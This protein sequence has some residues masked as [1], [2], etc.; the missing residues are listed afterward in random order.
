MRVFFNKQLYSRANLTLLIL[1]CFLTITN[2]GKSQTVINGNVNNSVKIISITDPGCADCDNT[3]ACRYTIEV[4]DANG[5]NVGDRVLIVQ[6]KGATIDVTN[7]AAGGE[8]TDIG[9]AGNYEFFIVGSVDA[10]NN[11]IYPRGKLKRT[12]DDAGLVQLVKVPSYSGDTEINSNIIG[13]AWDPTT[14]HGGVVAIFVDGTL[15]LNADIDVSGRGYQGVQMLVNGT[16][17]DC[18]INPSTQMI[19][20]SSTSNGAFKGQGIVIDNSSYNKG[21]APRANGGGGGVSGDSGGGG[22]SNYGSG[23]KGGDRWCDVGGAPAGGLGGIAMSTYISQNRIFFGGAGGAGFV[24]TNNPSSAAHGGGL[25]I[26][27]AKKIIG[28][29]HLIN[30]AGTSPIAVNPTGSPDGGGGGGG[31]GTVVFEIQDFESTIN[32]DVSGGNG[33]DLNTNTI[34]GPG[35]GG[36]GGAFLYNLM[37]L[38]AGITVTAT[39]G[40]GGQHLNAERN[41]SVDGS[42]GGIV[43]YFNLVYSEE[44]ADNDDISDFCDLDTDNDG[45]PDADED[46]NTGFDPSKDADNDGIPN[47]KDNDDATPGFPAFVDTNGD[48]VNDVYDKDKDHI[49]DF[50]DLDSDNDGRVDA[51]EAGGLADA[52][53]VMSNYTDTDLDGLND[54]VDPDNGGT[55][56]SPTDFDNDGIPDFLDLD[57]DD[58]GVSDAYESATSTIATGNDDDNDGI[59]NAFDPD[60]SG[61]Y[62][63]LIDRDGDTHYDM[64]DIDSDNDGITDYIESSGI[65]PTGTDTDNDGIDDAYDVDITGGTDTDEDWIDDASKPKDKDADG[66]FDIYDIDADADGI[67]DNIEGQVTAGYIAPSGNDTDADGLDDAYDTDNGGTTIIPT[68][69]DGDLVA[70]FLDTNSDDDL[71]SDLIEAYDSDNDGVSNILPAGTDTDGDGLDDNYDAITGFDPT[72]GGEVP[73]DYPDLDNPGGDRDWRQN[74]PTV[75]LSLDKATIAENAE[76]ATITATLSNTTFVDVTVNLVYSGTASGTDYNAA[77]GTNA[78]N[79]VT[80]VIPAGQLI[81][82]V[83]I[84]SVQD[85]LEEANETVIVDVNSVVN[86]TESGT[87]TVTTTIVD[88]DINT[89]LRIVK[90]VDNE[91][92]SVG[93]NVIFTLTATNNGPSTATGVSVT[94]NLPTGYTYVSDDGAGAYSGG[95]WTIGNLANGASATLNI[96]VAVNASGNYNNTATIDG[97]QYDPDA[98][99]NTSSKSASPVAKADLSIAKSVDN[100]TPNVG[101]NIVFTLTVTNNGP[102]NAT[103][104]SVTD[105]LPAGYTYVSDDGSGAYSGGT[106]TVGNLANGASATLNITVSVNATGSYANT[107]S[108][109]GDQNDPDTT[110]DSDTNTPSPN[111]QTDLSIVKTVDNST[112]NVG[113]NVVFTL[114]VTNNGPNDATG[115]SITDNLPTGYTYVSDDGSGA[116]S[117]GI[118]TV[119]N[120]ANSTS[121]TLN[122]IAT[123][124]ASGNY[125]NTAS[126]TGNENDPDA[127][128]NTSSKTTTP[129]S[130]TDLSITKTVDNSTPNVG[131]N[132]VFTLT[133]TNNGPSDATGVSVTDNLPAGYTYVSDDGSGAYSGG[134]WTVGN[135]ANGA[136]ATLNIT[137][138][139]NATGS[140]A[141]TASVSGDQ[142]DPDATDD[143]DT[144]TPTPGL[145]TSPTAQ[146]DNVTVDED[147]G[148]NNVFVLTDNGNGADDFGDNGPSTGTINI[149]SLP[150]HGTATVND[151][152][153]PNDPTDDFIVYTPDSEYHGNDSFTYEIC[154]VD[155][156][157]AS[158]TVNIT[159]NSVNDLPVAIDDNAS[160]SVDGT[161]NSSV[162]GNDTGLGDTPVTFSLTTDVSNGTLTFNTDGTYTYIPNAGYVGNDSFTYTV[163]DTDGDCSTATVT[164]TIFASDNQPVAMNDEVNVNEDE[165]INS[166]VSGND[167]GLN[168]TPVT[169]T[170]ITDV[171]NGTL[172]LNTDG[173]FTYTPDENFNGEDGFTYTVCDVDGDCSNATVSITVLP[174]NDPPEANPDYATVDM[175][176]SRITINVAENDTDVDDNIDERTVILVRTS[177]NGSSVSVD[178]LGGINYTPAEGFYGID[179]IPYQIFDTDGLSDIDTLFVTVNA[180]VTVPNT[181]TPNGDGINDVLVIPGIEDYDNEIFIYNRWGN[182]VYHVV[183]Y[184]NDV[185]AWDGRAQNK[186][187]F[188]G[189]QILPVGTYFYILKLKGENKPIKGYVYLQY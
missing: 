6:M 150:T 163:C 3:P 55:P 81:G 37:S 62:N 183:N 100:S 104:V 23:G 35:G 128:D 151:N 27:R 58:D 22:G 48:G 115:V 26:I 130:Q 43:S 144:N 114:T 36:G 90:T 64:F 94:D 13:E 121:A 79:A 102:S 80:I 92:P 113:D 186:V 154:D 117:S 50:K 169:F 172:T 45:V 132:V 116:Y 105:N 86:G 49:P 78:T 185:N 21:R 118:W 72:D 87:Q 139:V 177:T 89:D 33:Q 178:G 180:A 93:D 40:R 171:D 127:T 31:G 187:K 134:T 9:N 147:S 123:V 156:D 77:A 138:S 84:T 112:P 52:S 119:G 12:Y 25:V 44:D 157:C 101:D 99:D 67:I 15:T 29:G 28:N 152:N 60:N 164:I 122:I 125:N 57:S 68:D 96:T 1:V 83:T 167:T 51:V 124:N 16:P 73:T 160:V 145:D 126:I 69:T 103:G 173:T 32:I 166:D 71:D 76:L 109:S 143:S 66:L 188:G 18:S 30:A 24:T 153:T 165:T 158:A 56:L 176:S 88:D 161:L 182:E 4:E 162:G 141:N 174:V 135:L 2:I 10:V 20:P 120:L 136:S 17:N 46:G 131:D 137:V 140:Y 159:V 59:D 148:N 129:V 181:F 107:A 47:Y 108:V 8:I 61:T 34:H 53:G 189:N 85:L 146:D 111:V 98:T 70:D 19:L 168:D 38:P 65:E 142:N 149:T 91:T 39:G 133:V 11:Y 74:I 54:V 95:T 179:T 184:N 5:F 14:G 110:D 63:V 82:T 106:W 170:L 155:G 175:N 97:D 41:G 42:D 75:S 7:T